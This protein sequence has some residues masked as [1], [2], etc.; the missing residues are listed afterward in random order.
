MGAPASFNMAD[1][2]EMAADAVPEREAVVV[3]DQ[4]LSYAGL[5]DRANRLAH[6]LTAQGV[7]PGDH[8]ALYLENCTEYL[9]AMLRPGSC[10]PFRSTSTTATWP[11]S[12]ATCSTT[13]T[14]WA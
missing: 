4:R 9:E 12:C 2:W 6:H 13:A 5:E 11:T 8:V 10:G 3:G 1:V 14:R 7:G